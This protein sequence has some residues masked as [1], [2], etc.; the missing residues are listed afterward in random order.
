MTNNY[1]FL[2]RQVSEMQRGLVPVDGEVGGAELELF[3]RT[4]QGTA[5]AEPVPRTPGAPAAS[6]LDNF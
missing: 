4:G 5:A 1:L 3:G 6:S 2:V